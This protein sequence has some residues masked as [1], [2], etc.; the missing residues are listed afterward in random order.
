MPLECADALETLGAFLESDVPGLAWLDLDWAA[1]S[2]HLPGSGSPRFGDLNRATDKE[3][4]VSGGGSNM[5]AQLEKLA[6]DELFDNLRDIL[7]R[8]IGEILRIPP[9]KIDENRSLLDVGMDSLMGM[10]LI[11][12]LEDSLGVSL[13]VMA[14]SEGPTIAKLAE[15]IAHV[16]QPP[17]DAQD[18]SE[19]DEAVR[20]KL[21]AAQHGASET[22]IQKLLEGV[23]ARK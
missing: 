1:L 22:E 2:R 4:P 3:G 15:R 6:P 7:K 14:L 17:A 20:Q 12:S 8:E 9:D 18:A 16:I 5:R 11:S 23:G 10:E 21:I 13:P 19:P